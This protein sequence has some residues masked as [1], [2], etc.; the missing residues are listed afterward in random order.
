MNIVQYIIL[1]IVL[2]CFT[3]F[4]CTKNYRNRTSRLSSNLF[5]YCQ[6]IK[7]TYEE[8]SEESKLKLKRSLNQKELYLFLQIINDSKSLGKNLNVLQGQMFVLESIMAKIKA[9]KGRCQ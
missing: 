6:F 8:L 7:D 4:T 5:E 9:V 2:I 3:I 1:I